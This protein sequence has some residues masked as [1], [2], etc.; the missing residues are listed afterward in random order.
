[1]RKNILVQDGKKIGVNLNFSAWKNDDL[2]K[3]ATKRKVVEKRKNNCIK[4][5]SQLCKNATTKETITKEKI[6]ITPLPPKLDKIFNQ[7]NQNWFGGN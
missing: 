7:T 4:T 3:N 1:M 5:Q 6:N 2:C